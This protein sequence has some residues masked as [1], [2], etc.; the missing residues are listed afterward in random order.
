MALMEQAASTNNRHA[1]LASQI[2]WKSLVSG[3]GGV[4]PGTAMDPKSLTI[5]APLEEG[6]TDRYL[7]SSEALPGQLLLVDWLPWMEPNSDVG[8]RISRA[9][10]LLRQPPSGRPELRLLPCAAYLKETTQAR[11]FGDAAKVRYAL[12]YQLPAQPLPQIPLRTTARTKTRSLRK[13]MLDTARHGLQL[14]LLETRINLARSLCRAMLLYHS[15]G[16]VHHDFRSHNVLFAHDAVNSQAGATDPLDPDSAT[17]AGVPLHRPYI[18]GL[19]Y[20][21]DEEE[22]SSTFADPKSLD[23]SLKQQRQRAAGAAGRRVVRA[24]P[25]RLRARLCHAR[26]RRVAAARVV[27]VAVKVRGGPCAVA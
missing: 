20:A 2:Q 3:M 19:G 8:D 23:Q 21:R 10:G 27:H 26:A 13:L 18:I 16:W 4:K 25:R 17:Y 24:Y 5:H 12:A 11:R 15:S 1:F 6:I 14:P 9:A 7:A 22:V